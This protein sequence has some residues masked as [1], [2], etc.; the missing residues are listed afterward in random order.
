M[1]PSIALCMIVKNE[2]K[3][4]AKCLTSVQGLVDEIIVVDTGS[5][6]ATVN[7]AKQCQASV[8]HFEWVNSFAA[9]RNYALEQ[10]KSDYILVLDA[11]EYLEQADLRRDLQSGQDYYSMKIKNIVGTGSTFTHTAVRLF[12]NMP[13]LRFENRLHEHLNIN[14]E[15]NAGL[16][17]GMATTVIQHVG[18][19][20][21]T[22]TEKDKIDRNLKLILLDVKENPSG[23]NL[24]N[25][26]KAHV[27]AG[28]FAGAI[29]YF[30][31]SYPLSTNRVYLP[32]LLTKLGLCLYEL[33]R[34]DEAARVLEDGV[35]CFPRESD[36]RY[37]QGKNF[38]RMGYLKDAEEA[39]K[40]CLEIGDTGDMVVEGTGG[41]L[42]RLSLSEVYELQGQ[43]LKSFDMI[44]T[45]AA[46]HHNL[47]PALVKYLEL[48]AK[49]RLP[50]EE[51]KASMAGIF[52]LA[53]IDDLELL[54]K[55]L[56]NV[57]HP[58]LQ[59]YI[60]EYGVNVERNVLAVAAMYAKDYKQAQ[61]YWEELNVIPDE[62]VLDYT[63]LAFLSRDELML[64]RV[65]A[66]L[67]WS[68]KELKAYGK[69]V[70]RTFEGEIPSGLG[71]TIMAL[72]KQLILLQGQEDF[73]YMSRLIAGSSVELRLQLAELLADYR[74]TGAAKTTINNI[75]HQKPNH[76]KS[77]QLLGGL[78]LSEGELQ[79]ALEHYRKAALYT[80]GYPAF[81]GMYRVLQGMND[82]AGASGVVD[83]IRAQFPN[84]RW[85]QESE[86][87]L[88]ASRA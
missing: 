25:A 45:V 23:Y 65:K 54:L 48:T 26:G 20:D 76:G 38:L 52:K 66:R 6:D 33:G 83:R 11:D 85:V 53:R 86:P 28:D 73:D 59:V 36:L 64:D 84:C 81:E 78:Y 2:E 69:I 72:C 63:L 40:A 17:G 8:Y 77:H 60:R 29:P 10:A 35:N 22:M 75:F 51:V 41:Y 34:C 56:Y 9:A 71:K 82:K 43:M 37:M 1:Y 70:S 31:K 68:G 55:V 61:L 27:S 88:F 15:Q 67:N 42:A 80:N 5:T 12:R 21:E 30:Q 79:Q 16:K 19:S 39:F 3:H 62:N 7:I 13:R 46:E 44:A 58:L 24:F 87:Q 57:K 32:E 14:A 18:Y 4:L 50:L 49:L 74:L 47:I